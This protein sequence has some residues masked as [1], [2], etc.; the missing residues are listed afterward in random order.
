[1]ALTQA[2]IEAEIRELLGKGRRALEIPREGFTKAINRSLRMLKRHI[3]EHRYKVQ[4]NVT[5]K[6]FIDITTGDASDDPAPLGVIDVKFLDDSEGDTDFESFDVFAHSNIRGRRYSFVLLEKVD[7]ENRQ[8]VM[9]TEPD[10][11][12]DADNQRLFIYAPSDTADVGY[13]VAYPI[14]NLSQIPV[15]YEQLFMDCVEGHIRISLADIR[16]KY[17]GRVPGPTG[18]ITLDADIQRTV[19]NE[20]LQRIREDL[21]GIQDPV[22]PLWG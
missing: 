7:M 12:Y 1:M 21:A 10:W 6:T 3:Q 5:N 4:E 14:E 20:I 13:I 18:D 17:G 11:H 8:R 9:G 16:G 15:T 2:I 22:P 19:G